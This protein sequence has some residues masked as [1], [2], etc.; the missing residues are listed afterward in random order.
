MTD[1]TKEAVEAELIHLRERVRAADE[2][3]EKSLTAFNWI[4]MMEGTGNSCSSV[5]LRAALAAYRA[6]GEQT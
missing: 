3:Y 5:R 6:T 1:T 2:L 4:E